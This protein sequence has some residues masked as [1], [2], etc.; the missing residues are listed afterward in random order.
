MFFFFGQVQDAQA[1][2]LVVFIHHTRVVFIFYLFFFRFGFG[3]G[4]DVGDG[5]AA[6]RPLER[7][8][9][10]FA[11]GYRR[12]FTARH[13]HNVN[14]LFIAAAIGK[15]RQ[16]FSIGRPSWPGLRFFG[17]RQ[18]PRRAALFVIQPDMADA[19]FA[20]Q[21]LGTTNATRE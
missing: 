11:F 7:A 17:E 4:R 15:E 19:L 1:G 21:G 14:L 3:V 12:G 5:L 20:L 8:D 2:M 13:A 18:L 6:G 16:L 9:A 10:R